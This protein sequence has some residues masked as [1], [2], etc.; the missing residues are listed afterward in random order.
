MVVA[1][2]AAAIGVEVEPY[3]LL[4][5]CYTK[6]CRHFYE[7]YAHMTI[8][9]SLDRCLV[10]LDDHFSTSRTDQTYDKRPTAHWSLGKQRCLLKNSSSLLQ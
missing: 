9:L 5:F 3:T 8:Q 4:H 1:V 7:W 2:A 10:T 6:L